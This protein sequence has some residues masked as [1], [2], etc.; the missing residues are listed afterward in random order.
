MYCTVCMNE[1]GRC[2]YFQISQLFLVFMHVN[3]C[4]RKGLMSDRKA[5]HYDRKGSTLLKSY[6]SGTNNF[7]TI[8][9]GIICGFNYW[10]VQQI[11]RFLFFDVW[12]WTLYQYFSILYIMDPPC[13]CVESKSYVYVDPYCSSFHALPKFPFDS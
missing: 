12:I 1:S 10:R 5:R 11:W 6:K 4:D 7:R 2:V 3:D 9:S 13:N 8:F